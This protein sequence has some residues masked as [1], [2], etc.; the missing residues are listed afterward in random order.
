MQERQRTVIVVASGLA[1]AVLAV[2]INRDL[3]D[4]D[5]G[6]FAYAPNTGATF[7]PGST[8]SAIWREAAIWIGA[9]AAWSGISLWLYRRPPRG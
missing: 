7:D 6:W 8:T 3:S 4:A 9:I 2:A 5:G 1:L